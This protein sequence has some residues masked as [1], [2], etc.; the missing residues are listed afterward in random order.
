MLLIHTH[1]GR[2]VASAL[3]AIP[4]DRGF[5]WVEEQVATLQPELLDELRSSFPD[6]TFHR[7]AGGEDVKDP[8]HLA[9]LWTWL[10]EAGATR[11]SLLVIVGGGALLD[12]AGLAA[13]TYMRGI[14]TVYI[15]TTLLAMVDASIGGKTAIDFLGVKNLIGAFHQ[16][17]ETCIDVRFLASLPLDELLSGYGEVIKHALLQ[18]EEA[19]RSLLALGDPQ[20][21]SDEDW[22]ELITS[23]VRYKA[24]IVAADPEEKDL[25]RILNLGHTVGHALEAYARQTP[26][27]RKLTH[28]EAV[29]FGILI[30][31]Y[32]TSLLVP[33]TERGYLRQLLAL[34]RELYEPYYYVCSA[35]PELLTLM[36]SDKKNRGGKIT[37]MGLVRPGEVRPLVVEEEEVIRQGLDFLRE[38][39]GN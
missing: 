17:V 11:S 15:P 8:N 27:G 4:R 34:A 22:R 32:I 29:V 21:L 38:T 26:G 25:R 33:E 39:F 19:W 3:E 36:R 20:A 6:A 2:E 9:E 31:G 7:F 13:A 10:H 1:L 14:R 37:L 23:N 35:Y 30:E 5:F 18:G 16:P 12:L 24:S 28:G